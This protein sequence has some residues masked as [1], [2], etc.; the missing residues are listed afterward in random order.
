MY[1]LYIK[2]PKI[3]IVY[4]CTGDNWLRQVTM[5]DKWQTRPL[6]R[7]GAPHGQDGNFQEW[8]NI[9]SWAPDG[10]RHQ[11]RQADWLSVAM[12]LWLT[13]TLTSV[14]IS[15]HN[16][17]I[18]NSSQ[19]HPTSVSTAVAT[20]PATDSTRA[21]DLPPSQPATLAATLQL[22]ITEL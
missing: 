11:D 16:A 1:I 22:A 7:E 21:V 18:K 5:T 15:H 13:L 6:V 10:A 20:L 9:W 12:W 8:I 2:L 19:Q 17:Y 4:I 3:C 14:N